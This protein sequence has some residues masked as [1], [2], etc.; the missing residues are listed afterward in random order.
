MFESDFK[1]CGRSGAHCSML[2]I[3][4]SNATQAMTLPEVRRSRVGGREHLVEGSFAVD[5]EVVLN[6]D[7][8]LRLGDPG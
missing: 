2:L 3:P 6:R 8:D 1:S 4:R 7:H 5:V